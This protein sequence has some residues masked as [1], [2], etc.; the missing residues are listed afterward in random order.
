MPVTLRQLG[1]VAL[2]KA[3]DRALDRLSEINRTK[4]Y[5]SQGRGIMAESESRIA[6]FNSRNASIINTHVILPPVHPI[7]DDAPRDTEKTVPR[8]TN[9]SREKGEFGLERKL[10]AINDILS[11]EFL[12]VGLLAAKSVGRLTV[13]GIPYGTGFLVGNQILIT[14]HHVIG[15]IEDAK[16]SI[17]ELN[18]EE[19]KYGEPQRSYEYLLN[20]DRFFLTNKKLDFTLVAVSDSTGSKASLNEFGWHVLLKVQ[21]K[22]RKGDPVNILHHPDGSNKKIVVHN[23]HFLHLENKTK[24]DQYCWYSGDTEEG[25]SGAPLF[26]NRWEVLALHHKAVPKTNKNGEIVDKKGRAMSEKRAIENPEDIAWVANEGVRISRIVEAIEKKE[27]E[28]NAYK[29]IRD[30]LLRLWNSP[31]AHKKGI[32][33]AEP[34]KN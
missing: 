18:V 14:N 17:L 21:G 25:S 29:K 12:E 26:N 2:Q 19:N 16:N 8:K 24:Y 7:K 10:G 33:A 28:V 1:D 22:V 13:Y 32:E 27:F 5:I 3:T 34:K 20:P 15:T 6:Q 23:S 11:I 4:R 31:M 30:Q 9:K